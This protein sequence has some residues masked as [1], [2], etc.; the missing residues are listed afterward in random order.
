MKRFVVASLLAASTA[1]VGCGKTITD[2]DCKK[3]TDNMREV[4]AAEAKKATPAEGSAG[5]D[6]AAGVI[7]DEGDKLTADWSAE[8][9]KELLGRRVDPK[10]MD[11]SS[12]RRRSSRSRS[13]RSFEH[14]PGARDCLLRG[15]VDQRERALDRLPELF[16]DDIVFRDPFRETSGMDAF[17]ELFTSMFRRYR[18]VRFSGFRTAVGGDGFTSTYDMH[19]RMA[20]GPEFT[21]PFATVCR[22]RGEKVSE[23]VDYYDFATGLV[24]PFPLAASL[25]RSVTRKLFM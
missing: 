16:T 2:D 11:C 14:A 23:L 18:S 20:I 4:W 17:R 1:M 6:K 7:K 15:D 22:V 19:L 13:A 25:Y 12:R 24:S 10:E 8:C 9:K 5:A 3:I 21:T